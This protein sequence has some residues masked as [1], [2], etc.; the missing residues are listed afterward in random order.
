MSFV[1]IDATQ[2]KAVISCK[3]TL[4][5]ID[6][7][8]PKSLRKY[9]VENVY[10][11]AETCDEKR[12]PK[13]REAA[14]KAGYSGLWCLYTIGNDT[15]SFKTD[16]PALL[17]FGDTILRAATRAS[18]KKSRSGKPKKLPATKRVPPPRK[19]TSTKKQS[20]K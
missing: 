19:T 9:G 12:L 11:F 10:L 16:E 8:H 3:S 14:L 15:A 20:Q 7:E 5:S 4:T 2:A 17:S 18:R 13:L 1:F 6:K